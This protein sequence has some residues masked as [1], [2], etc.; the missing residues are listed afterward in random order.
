MPD[1]RS[2]WEWAEAEVD[3]SRCATYE[4]ELKTRYSAGY[5]PYFNEIQEAITDREVSEIWVL[6]NSRAGATE[7]CLLNPIRWAVSRGGY[8]IL[9]ISGNEDSAIDFFEK[10]IKDGL[11]LCR[12][13]KAKLSK[14]VRNDRT[15]VY[16]SDGNLTVTWPRNKMA[17][18]ASGYNLILADEVSIWGEYSTDMLRKRGD[19]WAF[20]KIVGVSSP[21]PQQKRPSESDPIFIEYG[22]G[23]MRRWHCQSPRQGGDFVFEMGNQDSPHGLKWDQ[24]AKR[25][26]GSWDFDRVYETAHYVCPDGDIITND[27]RMEI[28]RRGRWKPTA[29]K[30][31]R[32]G[33]RSYHVNSFMSPFKSGDFGN[34]A[35][36]FLKASSRGPVGLKTFVYEYLAE[37][38]YGEKQTIEV[39]SV[40]QRKG[41][42]RH[43]QRLLTVPAYE[44]LSRRPSQLIL[45][46]DVQKDRF[47]CVVREWFDGGDSALVEFAEV[48][49]FRDIAALRAKHNVKWSFIDLGYSERRN[50]VL[51]Q[52]LYGEIKGT[53]PMFGRD[54]LK[55]FHAVNKAYDPFEGTAKQGRTKMVM[56]TFNPDMGKHILARLMDGTDSHQWL[57]PSDIAGEYV[58][59]ITA[60]EC[61]DGAW[62]KRH[63]ENHALDDE[64][65]QLVAACVLGI[66]RQ[67]GISLDSPGDMEPPPTPPAARKRGVYYA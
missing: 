3:F 66:F 19:N 49:G 42:Y 40:E 33:V 58:R 25:E 30:P 1:A 18:K 41:S 10:R 28:V 2:V 32:G 36:A 12:S 34:I 45:T 8:H 14:A 48:Q 7:N 11:K 13:S 50:E 38:W 20:S 65:M 56:V 26:D 57:I 63:R 16:F 15:R 62:V 29:T 53:I 46:T 23:D 47:I 59:Q 43:G 5:L 61:I 52:C 54:T 39:D 17:F 27:R 24:S 9:F 22:T 55:E 51:E 35:V 44:Y 67:A 6:K 31:V 64:N 21:D 37:P 4:T 60:E